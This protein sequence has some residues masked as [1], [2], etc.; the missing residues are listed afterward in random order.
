MIYALAVPRFEPIGTLKLAFI[1]LRQKMFFWIILYI[2]IIIY[3]HLKILRKLLL[4]IFIFKAVEALARSLLFGW[5]LYILK[6]ILKC[7]ID[8]INNNLGEQ[9]FPRGGLRVASGQSIF[10]IFFLVLE[11]LFVS[12]GE[13][14]DR[15]TLSCSHLQL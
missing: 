1:L 14:P 3:Y 11:F 9:R 5:K 4:I 6:E 7:I 10:L 8:P 15:I 12:L 2:N 13:A